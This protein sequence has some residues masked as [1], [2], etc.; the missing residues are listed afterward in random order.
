MGAG[1]HPGIIAIAP[2]DQIVPAFRAGAGMV[3]DFVSRHT[4]CSRQFLRDLVEIGGQRFAGNPQ[5]AFLVQQGGNGVSGSMV[6]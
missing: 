1:P 2:I 3:G 6:S 5:L 4:R